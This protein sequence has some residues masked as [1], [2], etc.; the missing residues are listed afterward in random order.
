MSDENNTPKVESA[1]I[2]E[3]DNGTVSSLN[4]GFEITPELA[5]MMEEYKKRQIMENKDYSIHS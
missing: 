4:F 1:I 5:K 2:N 3:S